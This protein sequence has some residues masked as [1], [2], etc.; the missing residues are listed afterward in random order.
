[1]FEAMT[2]RMKSCRLGGEAPADGSSMTHTVANNAPVVTASPASAGPYF[3]IGG[4]CHWRQSPTSSESRAI[5]LRK[6]PKAGEPELR[7][8]L[9]LQAP[10]ASRSRSGR[11]HDPKVEGSN[12][13]PATRKQRGSARGRTPF[14]FRSGE[15]RAILVAH[16]QRIDVAAGIPRNA[17]H[18]NPGDTTVQALT[19]DR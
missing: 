1:M 3:I 5:S 8:L 12:P 9:I 2:H 18:G 6:E 17:T 16:R 10:V 19:R 11:P 15:S 13:S 14:S 4:E 7:K